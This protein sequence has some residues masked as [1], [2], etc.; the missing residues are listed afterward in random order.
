MAAEKKKILVKR[1][2]VNRKYRNRMKI[3]KG[4]YSQKKKLFRKVK[5]EWKIGVVLIKNNRAME[6]YIN[7]KHIKAEKNKNKGKKYLKGN[8]R[9]IYWKIYMQRKENYSQKVLRHR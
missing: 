4:K 3:R 5:E 6:Q 9:K 8:R 7:R 1:I 2:F